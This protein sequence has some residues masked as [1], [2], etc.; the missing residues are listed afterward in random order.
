MFRYVGTDLYIHLNG[1]GELI[2]LKPWKALFSHLQKEKDTHIPNFSSRRRYQIY[3]FR[4][5]DNPMDTQTHIFS[6]QIRRY[7]RI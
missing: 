4:Y 2:H 1:D 3:K 7:I 5:F 6:H